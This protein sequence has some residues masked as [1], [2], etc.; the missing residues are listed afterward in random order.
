[1]QT[2]KK[3]RTWKAHEST[4]DTKI[5]N[6]V[7]TAF[8]SPKATTAA[9]RRPRRG[10]SRNSVKGPM[11][12]ANGCANGGISSHVSKNAPR[13]LCNN[14]HI[15]RK[16]RKSVNIMATNRRRIALAAVAILLPLLADIRWASSDDP[17]RFAQEYQ[18]GRLPDLGSTETCLLASAACSRLQAS[19]SDRFEVG[20]G[21]VRVLAR[22]L[23]ADAA[24][25]RRRST[26]SVAG[27]SLRSVNAKHSFHSRR[28]LA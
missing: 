23:A 9:K 25:R 4:V 22:A 11:T 27:S 15:R 14:D 6:T 18:A 5:M 21:E 7:T 20:I 3:P 2:A 8:R 16:R 10:S 12:N 17:M 24:V 13:M 1:M 26:S 28:R 19:C